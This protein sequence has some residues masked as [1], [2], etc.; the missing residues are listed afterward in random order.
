MKKLCPS[1]NTCSDIMPVYPHYDCQVKK[2]CNTWDPC[3]S[4]CQ[5]CWVRTD[6]TAYQTRDLVNKSSLVNNT[7]RG[8]PYLGC[9]VNAN[10]HRL[11]GHSHIGRTV[12]ECKFRAAWKNATYFGLEH[13]HGVAKRGEVPSFPVVLCGAVCT[14]SLQGV[15]FHTDIF[16]G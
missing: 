16:N 7:V 14:T 10:E 5:K 6:T 3:R 1:H 11:E 12:N 2:A 4:F 15:F 8:A 9:F 13:P